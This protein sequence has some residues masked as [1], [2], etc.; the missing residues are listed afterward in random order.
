MKLPSIA[1]RVKSG[2][3]FMDSIDPDWRECID[4]E[5]LDMG[6]PSSC[7]IGQYTKHEFPLLDGTYLSNWN[8]FME[9]CDM[10]FHRGGQKLQVLRGFESGHFL[11]DDLP[12][13]YE[14]LRVE[15]LK[16]L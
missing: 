15:W 3:E 2:V 11:D 5:Q 7:I 1:D 6:D 8:G 14:D 16:Y 9:A 10:S 12:N 4:G 13:D